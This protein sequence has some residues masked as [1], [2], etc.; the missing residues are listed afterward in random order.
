MTHIVFERGTD[1]GDQIREIRLDDERAWPERFLE[2][3]FRQRIGPA[4][5]ELEEEVERLGR[6]VDLLSA[7]AQLPGERVE[8][9]FAETQFHA[10]P[11]AA[12][13]PDGGTALRRRWLA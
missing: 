4:F 3:C 1:V 7:A 6:D 5:D 8:C 10:A 2:R 13:L 12:S 11:G 9:E